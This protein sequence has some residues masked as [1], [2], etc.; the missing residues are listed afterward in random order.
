VNSLIDT[1]VWIDSFR[2]VAPSPWRDARALGRK[3][4]D[5]GFLPPSMDLLIAQ[6]ALGHGAT[7]VT[8]DDHFSRIAGVCP[9]DARL[10]PRPA[11]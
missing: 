6:L 4:F 3:C 1:S 5:A 7:I 9:L 2:T 10:L 11:H 8:F